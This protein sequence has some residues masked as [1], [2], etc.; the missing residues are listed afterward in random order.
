M[1]SAVRTGLRSPVS[2]LPLADLGHHGPKADGAVSLGPARPPLRLGTRRRRA[3]VVATVVVAGIIAVVGAVAGRERPESA[4]ILRAEGAAPAFDLPGVGGG[5]D[6]VSLAQFAGRPLV[7]NFWASWCVPCRDEMPALQAAGERL[8]GRVAFVGINH[9]DD[10][11][12]AGEFER[13]VGV[14][15]ASGADPTGDV[16]R[17]YGARGLPTTV[18]VD[19]RGDIV[20]RQL[21]EIT[22]DE[23]LEL[24]RRA[25]GSAI[26]ESSS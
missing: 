13:E 4:D 10:P 16:A 18:L 3:P 21:G 23:L 8:A 11:A 1:L 9:Q 2:A 17:Q 6:R 22:E 7:I 24:V 14:R 26:V 20:A 15:Y 19:A 25:F 12:A 5:G